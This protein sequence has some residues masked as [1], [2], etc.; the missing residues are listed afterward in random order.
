[1]E[2][3]RQ[4]GLGPGACQHTDWILGFKYRSAVVSFKLNLFPGSSGPDLEITV[5]SLPGSESRTML[6]G[7]A[8]KIGV[9]C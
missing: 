1:M 7:F 6:E 4:C 5:C 3:V 8:G 9:G 2:E